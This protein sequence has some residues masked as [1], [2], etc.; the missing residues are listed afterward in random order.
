MVC[1][2]RENGGVGNGSADDQERRNRSNRQF[3]SSI[4]YPHGLSLL[5]LI[6]F[7][8]EAQL[9]SAMEAALNSGS[10]SYAFGYS[11]PRNEVYDG[12]CSGVIQFFRIY[13]SFFIL[14]KLSYA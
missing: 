13:F 7:R 6:C 10:A 9:V 3:C 14:P 8:I 4:F 1:M 2:A 11:G 5:C 12:G